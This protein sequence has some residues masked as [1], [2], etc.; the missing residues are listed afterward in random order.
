[1]QDLFDKICEIENSNKDVKFQLKL[2]YYEIYNE[3]IHDL[4]TESKQE[5]NERQLTIHE[6][7]N[8]E[9]YV[10][11][12]NEIQVSSIQEVLELIRMGE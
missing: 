3:V 4:L 6:G 12:A 9:F 8:K 2:S 7:K 1:M 11:G 10:K 5:I